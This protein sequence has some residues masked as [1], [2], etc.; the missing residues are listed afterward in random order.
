M[1]LLIPKVSIARLKDR[2]WK[3]LKFTQMGKFIAH[4]SQVIPAAYVMRGDRRYAEA[5]ARMFFAEPLCGA[6]HSWESRMP[7][8]VEPGATS[9]VVTSST[10]SLNFF[11]PDFCEVLGLRFAWQVAGTVTALV[12][13]FDLYTAPNAAGTATDKLDGTNGTI[14]APTVAG[15]AIG[16]VLYKD[17]GDTL[18]IELSPGNSV[19]FIVT[20]TTSAG[21][22]VPAVMVVPHAETYANLSTAIESA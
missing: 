19:Q 9:P 12:A 3:S 17:I 2:L 5:F 7:L 11:V 14:T 6:G 13:D 18:A 1:N 10:N 21:S 16:N 20:T 22:G 15:Q 8:P 4:P